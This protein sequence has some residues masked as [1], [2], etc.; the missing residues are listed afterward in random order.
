LLVNLFESYD[1]ARTC[2]NQMLSLISEIKM[3]HTLHLIYI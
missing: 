2:E 3:S 1:D